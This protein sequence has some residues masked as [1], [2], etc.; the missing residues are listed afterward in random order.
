MAKIKK[1][2]KFYKN[3]KFKEDLSPIWIKLYRKNVNLKLIKVKLLILK[4]L[5]VQVT[6]M[7]LLASMKFKNNIIRLNIYK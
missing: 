5:L 6:M 4:I 1:L 2:K 3:N 7:Y